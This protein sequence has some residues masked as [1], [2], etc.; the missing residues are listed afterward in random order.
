M[1]PLPQNSFEDARRQL[2]NCVLFRG[3]VTGPCPYAEAVPIGNLV[4]LADDR[5]SG[6]VVLTAP[7]F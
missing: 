7:S 1:A 2:A 3:L 6:D 5:E 4:R